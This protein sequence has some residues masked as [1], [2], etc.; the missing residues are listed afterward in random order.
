[1]SL[2]TS[3]PSSMQAHTVGAFGAKSP[4]TTCWG[5]AHDCSQP[6]AKMAPTS[7]MRDGTTMMM[8]GAGGVKGAGNQ[9]DGDGDADQWGGCCSTGANTNLPQTTME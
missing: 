6:F 1:M 8:S 3:G 7:Q 4:G 2:A 5:G 9:E